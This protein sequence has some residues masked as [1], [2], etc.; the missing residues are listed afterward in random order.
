MIDPNTIEVQTLSELPFLSSTLPE[1]LFLVTHLGESFKITKSTLFAEVKPL[2]YTHSQMI[3]SSSWTINHNLGFEP[4]VSIVDSG[5]NVVFGDVLYL[6][7][8]SIQINFS[9]GFSG[10]AYL[11]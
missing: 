2:T 10:K 4:A 8:N 5:G 11:N 9:A 7:N 3:P 1:D 6:N